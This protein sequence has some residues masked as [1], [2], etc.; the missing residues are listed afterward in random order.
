MEQKCPKRND[1]LLIYSFSTR[2]NINK[3]YFS[4]FFTLFCSKRVNYYLISP[5]FCRKIIQFLRVFFYG[6]IYPVFHRAF[7]PIIFANMLTYNTWLPIT[8]CPFSKYAMYGNFKTNTFRH[9]AILGNNV[10]Y[11][12]ITLPSMVEVT[13]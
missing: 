5:K 6:F 9:A 12:V 8:Y 1:I 2:K 10:A 13:V 7:Y 3:I 11:A 4:L